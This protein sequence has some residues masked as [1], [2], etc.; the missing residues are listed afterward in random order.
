MLEQD[1]YR[2][3][4]AAEAARIVADHPWATLVSDGPVVSH[5]PLLLDGDDLAVVGHLAREDA[6]QHGLGSRDVVVV[7]QGPHGYISPSWYEASSYVP[8]WNYVTVHLHGRP[9]LLDGE[10]AFEVLRRTVDRFEPSVGG[11]WSLAGVEDYARRI[12]GGVVAFRLVPTRV[13][14]KAKLSQDKPDAIVER[15]VRRLEEPG[16]F[17]NPALAAEMRRLTG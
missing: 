9:E 15:V 1:H 10:A 7:V 16:P 2:V 4:E 14:A 8:T 3:H 13:V 5:L 11:D 17:G 6:R 12:A